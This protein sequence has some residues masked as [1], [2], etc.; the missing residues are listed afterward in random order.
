MLF[1][2]IEVMEL[3]K[4]NH[5]L[6]SISDSQPI[7]AMLLLN[8]ILPFSL[9]M[10]MELHK[11]NHL[12]PTISN[13]QPIRAMLLLSDCMPALRAGSFASARAGI[14]GDCKPMKCQRSSEKG[15]IHSRRRGP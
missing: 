7:R 11:T 13:S 15:L 9:R 6:L 8:S 10:V 12:L 2:F 1:S 14:G 5:L 4:T 3:Q